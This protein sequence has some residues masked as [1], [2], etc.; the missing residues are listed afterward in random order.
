MSNVTT[1]SIRPVGPYNPTRRPAPIADQP[2][3]TVPG[4]WNPSYPSMPPT[5]SY[6][7]YPAPM[8][9]SSQ[10]PSYPSMPQYPSYPQ[11]PQYPSYPQQPYP[12]YPG[13][14]RSGVGAFFGDVWR[15]VKERGHEVGQMVLHPLNSNARRPYMGRNPWAPRTTG[16]TVGRWLVNGTM[17]AGAVV[18][19]RALLG[20]GF[21]SIGGRAG[22]GMSS[23]IGQVFGKIAEVVVTPFRWAGNA[24]G[25]V[26]SGAKDLLGG[27]F[28]FI[29][30]GA[31]VGMR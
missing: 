26:F 31:R 27:M 28:S 10:Y 19:V 30:G 21:P 17:I 1:S 4:G 11:Q 9:P 3:Q 6:P 15:G 7:S 5:P 20:G 13:Q 29:G 14:P 22:V 16:E 12:Q 8:P 18:G 24:I 25:A 2:A 23:G